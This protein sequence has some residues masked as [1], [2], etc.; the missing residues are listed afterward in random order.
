[1]K[2]CAECKHCSLSRY[3]LRPIDPGEYDCNFNAPVSWITG[4]QVPTKCIEMNQ[5]G[6]CPHWEQEGEQK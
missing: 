2:I 5:M 1:M 4:L 6:D 3:S